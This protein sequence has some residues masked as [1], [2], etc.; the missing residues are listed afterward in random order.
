MRGTSIG[1]SQDERYENV[2]SDVLGLC[3][4]MV[5]LGCRVH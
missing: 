2:M 1:V 5:A 3:C 4:F